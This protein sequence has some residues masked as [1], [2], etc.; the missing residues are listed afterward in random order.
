MSLR[1]L[2]LSLAAVAVCCTASAQLSLSYLGGTDTAPSGTGQSFI[3]GD[4]GTF[5]TSMAYLTAMTFQLPDSNLINIGTAYL[6]IY[7]NAGLSTYVG[8][9]SNS[10]NWGASDFGQTKTFTFGN[11]ALDKNTTYYAV[12]S[13][14]ATAGSIVDRTIV[15]DSTNPFAGGQLIYGGT[16]QSGLDANFTAT[17]ATS[18]VPEPST[19]ALLAGV[20]A[21]GLAA[22]RRRRA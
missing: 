4:A 21:L 16:P 15:Y 7:S 6:D 5:P 14:D 2:F 20:A 3:P 8:S 9:S 17:F 19:Y 22:L 11:L 10:Q 1:S 13:S 12:F 18:A